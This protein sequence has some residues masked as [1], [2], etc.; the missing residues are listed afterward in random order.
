M[1]KAVAEIEK[2]SKCAIE[3]RVEKMQ[4]ENSSTK[5]IRQRE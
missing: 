3:I 4:E 2:L 1:E 5:W